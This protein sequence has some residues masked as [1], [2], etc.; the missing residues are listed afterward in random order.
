VNR[1]QPRDVRCPRC[2]S[3]PGEACDR[4]TVRD[5]KAIAT[6]PRRVSHVARFARARAESRRRPP[7][8]DDPAPAP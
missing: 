1:Y 4:M 6:G 3:P 8:L 2:G 5:G 7:T